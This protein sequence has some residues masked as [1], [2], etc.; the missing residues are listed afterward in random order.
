MPMYG[1]QLL[2]AAW[3]VSQAAVVLRVEKPQLPVPL[4]GRLEIPPTNP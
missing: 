2:R 4:R 1:Q 3:D